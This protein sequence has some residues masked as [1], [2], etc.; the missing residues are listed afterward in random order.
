MA[1]GRQ[2]T[3]EVVITANGKVAERV[4]GHLKAEAEKLKEKLQ[5][6]K[7]TGRDNTQEFKIMEGELKALEKSISQVSWAEERMGEYMNQISGQSANRLRITGS[8]LLIIFLRRKFGC[9]RISSYL[10]LRI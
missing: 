10:C 7:N 5:L 1:S 6:F 8:V 4:M 9:S 3:Y 2:Q